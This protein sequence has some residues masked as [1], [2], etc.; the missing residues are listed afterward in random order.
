M[1]IGAVVVDA[2]AADA[3]PSTDSVAGL[4]AATEPAFRLLRRDGVL[5]LEALAEPAL[6]RLAVDLAAGAVGWR[7]G[8]RARQERLVRACRVLRAGDEPPRRVLDGTGGLGTDAWLLA[9][10][11]A[12]VTVVEQHPV[13]RA[14]LQ[15]G[16]RRAAVPTPEIAAR[17]T[18]RAGDT[19][20]CV[21]ALRPE[22]LYLDPM[23]APRRKQALGDRR[24][25]LV[26]TLLAADALRGDD[27]GGL[28]RAGLDAGVE[29]V[30]LKCPLRAR[31]DGLPSPNHTLAGRSTRFDVWVS[32]AR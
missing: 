9:S 17:V 32:P 24:L 28:V 3:L 4:V 31:L 10:A 12:E 16:L 14:L 27:A 1:R 21:A 25:R 22:V 6:G 15:D 26:A 13:L 11:G 5:E 2:S 29:R 7:G 18:L 30:V 19:R 20:A 23:Y 8:A